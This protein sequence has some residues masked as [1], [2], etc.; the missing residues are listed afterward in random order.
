M[1]WMERTAPSIGSSHKPSRKNPDSEFLVRL[2]ENSRK[3]E[4]SSKLHQACSPAERM[5]YTDFKCV[6]I[7]EICYAVNPD[8]W[9]STYTKSD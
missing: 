4:S 2:T 9:N 5:F 8:K 3:S 6:M 1:K 7:F